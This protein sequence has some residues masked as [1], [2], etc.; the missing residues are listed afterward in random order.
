M[1]TIRT[2][3]CK[4]RP[5]R[6]KPKRDEEICNPICVNRK[7]DKLLKMNLNGRNVVLKTNI[8]LPKPPTSPIPSSHFPP[9]ATLQP[10]LSP[11]SV[12]TQVLLK[13]HPT[14]TINSRFIIH[15]IDSSTSPPPINFKTNS[16]FNQSVTI[17]F[18]VPCTY[19]FSY[20]N[21]KIPE[22][23]L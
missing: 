20:L 12:E 2:P 7:C 13:L 11:S 14:L 9:L 3:W 4:L 17:S 5:T 23:K 16:S 6:L 18:Y 19:N 22:K 8:P 1:Q 15:M 21:T 10:K